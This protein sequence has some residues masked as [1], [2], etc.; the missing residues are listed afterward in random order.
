MTDEVDDWP[1]IPTNEYGEWNFDRVTDFDL[2]PLFLPAEGFARRQ[3][4]DLLIRGSDATEAAFD[5]AYRAAV[6]SDD[7]TAFVLDRT[8]RLLHLARALT[9]HE[10]STEDI[11][12]LIAEARSI[13][14]AIRA[15][16]RSYINAQGE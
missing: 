4:L 11:S 14:A 1:F 9:D 7:V 13:V 5:A 6:T 10:L 8:P 15:D 16:V 12:A 3:V 2:Q